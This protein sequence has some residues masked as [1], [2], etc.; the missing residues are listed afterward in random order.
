MWATDGD[1]VTET[2]DWNRECRYVTQ[3]E[4]GRGVCRNQRGMAAAARRLS[5]CSRIPAALAVVTRPRTQNERSKKKTPLT[6]QQ[7]FL[8]QT[9]QRGR[10][11]TGACSA[12][13]GHVQ[14]L[15][16][17]AVESCMGRI[18]SRRRDRREREPWRGMLATHN[19]PVCG[20]YDSLD[21]NCTGSVLRRR[22]DDWMIGRECFRNQVRGEPERFKLSL[23]CPVSSCRGLIWYT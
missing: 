4:H 23:L 22:W 18:L 13:S 12:G 11:A 10:N 9:R 7:L 20:T 19:G 1:R 2:C 15:D 14:F 17:G 16:T 3:D 8:K 5:R 21:K 6:D